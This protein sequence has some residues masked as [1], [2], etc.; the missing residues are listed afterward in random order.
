MRHIDIIVFNHLYLK[1]P[2]HDTFIFFSKKKKLDYSSYITDFIFQN[3]KKIWEKYSKTIFKIK[4]LRFEKIT[5][6]LLR[7][8]LIF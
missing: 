1:T 4:N 6:N 5:I 2:T 8:S 7:F 3:D